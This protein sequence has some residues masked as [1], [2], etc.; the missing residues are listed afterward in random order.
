M[1]FAQELPAYLRTARRAITVQFS[2][3][4]L[5]AG[6]QGSRRLQCRGMLAI[7]RDAACIDRIDRS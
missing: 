5:S 3:V 7:L 6:T 2:K 4:P 1:S